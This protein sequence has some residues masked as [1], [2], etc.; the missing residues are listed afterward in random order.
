MVHRLR[1]L[2]LSA[3]LLLVAGGTVQ[4]QD[5]GQAKVVRCASVDRRDNY[6]PVEI[7]GEVRMLRQLSKA[8]CRQGSSWSFDRHGI[9]VSEGCAAEFAVARGGTRRYAPIARENDARTSNRG[10]Q[11]VCESRDYRYQYC[12]LR[13]VREVE[14]VRQLSTSNCRFRRSWGYDKNGVWVDQGCAAVFEVR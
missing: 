6:C 1:L 8:A 4:A 14:L 7:R 12:P 2:L 9:W 5:W 13:G 10:G 3:S 11:V